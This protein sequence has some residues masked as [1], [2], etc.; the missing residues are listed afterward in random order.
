MEAFAFVLE[1]LDVRPQLP[2]E[3]PLTVRATPRVRRLFTRTKAVT[4]LRF[5][6]GCTG[7]YAIHAVGASL[8]KN[9]RGESSLRRN[10]PRSCKYREQ[11]DESLGLL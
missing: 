2:G 7:R 1:L 3:A 10:V 6:V 5:S 9:R 8:R 4:A 11:K